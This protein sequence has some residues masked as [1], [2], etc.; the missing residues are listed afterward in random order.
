M[1]IA[2]IIISVSH[3]NIDRVYSY[4]IPAHMADKIRLGIRVIVPFGKGNTQR[5]GYV[6]G[7]REAQSN[8]PELL[9][10]VI[11]II[12]KEPVF[13]EELL[14]LARWMQ[15]KYYT[16]LVECINCIIPSGMAL[17]EGLTEKR[18]C[19]SLNPNAD[20]AGIKL[21][22]QQKSILDYL[23]EKGTYD[24]IALRKDLL[25]SESPIK[26]LE[27]KGLITVTYSDFLK[28]TVI[29]KNTKDTPPEY[30]EEQQKALAFFEN[31]T[32]NKPVLI[33]GVTG[34]GKTEIYLGLIDRVLAQGKQAIVLV[35]EISLTGQTVDVFVKRLGKC[36]S[37]THSR[38]SA[39]ERYDQWKKALTGQ[40]SV[41][42]GPRSAVFAPFTNLGI[43]IIDEEH[44]TTYKSST[45]PKYSAKEVA[46]ERGRRT[47]ATVV[48]GSAT[49]SVATYYEAETGKTDLITLTE[50][51]NKQ[52][53]QVEIVDMRAELE[54]GNRS[55][56]S[57]GL[58]NA[59]KENLEKK[60]QT[61]LF[62]N[63]RGHSTF[64]SCRKCG[65]V[66][67]CEN[68]NVNFTYHMSDNRLI[69]HYCGKNADNPK[70]CPVC[71]SKYIKYFGVGTQKVEDAVREFFPEA[72]VLRMDM[73][74]TKG[75]GT[76]DKILNLFREKRA[77][78]LIGTQMIAKGLDFPNV[79]LVGVI[80]ADVS[81]NN[82]DFQAGE[83]TFQL[84]TQV[85]GRA[86]RALISGRV[87][88]Q[89]Y[90]PDNYA[91]LCS[92]DND[93]VTF[94]KHE[95]SLRRQ[96]MY[97][98]FTH[99][100]S[101]LLTGPGEKAVITAL[102][103]LSDIM[104]SGNN[105]N[106]FELLGPSP[107]IISKIN[108]RYRWMILVKSVDEEKLKEFVLQCTEKLRSSHNLNDININLTLNPAF[109]N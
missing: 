95:I 23:Q 37:L 77:D 104:K 99:I 51:V 96:M 62:L 38:L 59:I 93:Y 90:S 46:T 85:S 10:E 58:Y 1:Q 33:H 94:Y 56:F 73:D 91:V 57:K 30:T 60:E 92:K 36:V 75:K 64:V 16:T 27:K 79:T 74:T 68:C 49:P 109:L 48:L 44:E 97:P 89:T 31:I 66:M 81:L 108:K 45:T 69:C 9:K 15:H 71:G 67:K 72:K 19:V 88:I 107:A 2:E 80:A 7:V 11:R 106:L 13:S 101:V 43:I 40:I 54:A 42:I 84:L 6:V 100:F 53:P 61:I 24:L 76:H 47:G 105:S 3:R 32:D 103:A 5:Q 28:D 83:H 8:D 34:S 52:F 63:R 20:T 70:N 29:Y 102:F 26:T 87:F 82:G 25:I 86:G 65:E 22:E 14:E 17:K 21:T 98:P 50:R 18:R 39:A 78:I 12:D 4:A 41:I 35:P 55:I